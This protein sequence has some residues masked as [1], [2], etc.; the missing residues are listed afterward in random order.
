MEACLVL[1]RRGPSGEAAAGAA[2]AAAAPPTAAAPAP[3]GTLAPPASAAVL[4]LLL[5][6]V[7]L[8]RP[9]RRRFPG[10]YGGGCTWAPPCRELKRERRWCERDVEGKGERNRGRRDASVLSPF[11]SPP[12]R[13]YSLSL[14]LFPPPIS[15]PEIHPEGR[16]ITIRVYVR[17]LFPFSSFSFS[18][19]LRD[20]IG[21]PSLQMLWDYTASKNTGEITRKRSPHCRLTFSDEIDRAEGTRE[22]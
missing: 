12:T 8:L 13:L 19:I 18:V 7:L 1:R 16:C 11:P 22:S 21:R 17:I 10:A 3:P 2:R 14:S 4:L 9:R 15:L 20:V 5:L 6:S